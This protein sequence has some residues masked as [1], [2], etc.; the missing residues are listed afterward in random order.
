MSNHL[1]HELAKDRIDEMLRRA[2]LDR[3]ARQSL[4]HGP[5]RPDVA[6][7]DQEH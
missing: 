5:R 1:H 7:P 3:L 6:H 2:E 4:R